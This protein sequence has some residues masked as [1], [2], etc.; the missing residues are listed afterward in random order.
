MSNNTLQFTI[1]LNGN[2]YTGIAQIDKAL[3]KVNVNAT[4]TESLMERINTA[5][6]KINNIF[7]AVQNTIGKVSGAIEKVIEVGSTNELQKM[8]MTTL[9][10]GNAEAAEEMFS[11]ISEYGKRTVYDKTGLIDAQKTMMSFGLSGKKSFETLKQIGDIAMGDKQKMQSLALAFSQATSAGKLQGQD[12][13]QLI[14]AGFN[15]LQTI[16]ERTGESLV[17]L[18]EKMS[19][20]QISAEMLAQAFKWATDENGLFY[21]GAMK[22]GTTTA[23]MI[24]Q[25]Q[26][27]FD[28]LLINI[29][30]KSKP[31]I[32]A[33][34]EIAT[35]VLGKIPDI[36][37]KVKSAISS[38]IV[39]IIAVTAAFVTYKTIILSVNAYHMLIGVWKSI[40]TAYEIVVF[41]VKNATSLWAAT[42]WL[43]NVAL[44][45]NPIA[46]VIAGVVALI[47]AITYVCS[48]ITGW[49]TLWDGVVGFMK[50]SFYAFVD[51]VKLYFDTYVNGFLMGL[52]KI[53]LGWYKFKEACGIGDSEENQ[54][55]I[56]AINADVVR[57]QKAITDGA[58]S[59]MDNALKAKNAITEG[60]SSL[61]W[62]SDKKSES[63]AAALGVNDQLIAA[64]NPGGGG[65]SL[66]G[67]AKESSKTTE[68]V[69][70]G[71]T[72]NTD[73]HINIGDMI[74]QVTF[75]GEVRENKNDIEKTFA[76]CL[77]QVLG[78][79]QTSI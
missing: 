59:V 32:D 27:S 73:I 57:R 31:I 49:G 77:Y 68:A 13:M 50:F 36:F 75:N 55:A 9:F 61:G 64:V 2:A 18:K 35:N 40:L 10:K 23:G 41:A 42:Q 5:A 44:S 51:A 69:A 15:P 52:D 21:E 72:R 46:F 53:K 3:N 26:D 17:S 19:K 24:G 11:K 7:G 54:K 63:A 1:N 8:N 48:K 47:A 37:N 76:E 4:K 14:N 79:A 22:A 62:K 74:R 56:A 66:N 58:K 38:L 25:L 67:L 71:G 12:L 28:E 29:F 33:C 60:F 43:L 30:S 16:S 39:P 45:A 6:F 34:L 70:T 78:M 20:G 65:M